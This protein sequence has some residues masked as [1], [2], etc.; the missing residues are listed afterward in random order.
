[1]DELEQRE[2]CF[3]GMVQ[4]VG[5][6]YSTRRLAA[7]Y[8]VTG[9]VQNLPDGRVRLVAEGRPAE[10]DRLVNAVKAEMEQYIDDVEVTVHP[11]GGQFH[12]FDIRF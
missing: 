11:A 5:F 4:G 9:Y 3:R 6:R 8:D 10:L 1:L 12:G 7:H 2:V